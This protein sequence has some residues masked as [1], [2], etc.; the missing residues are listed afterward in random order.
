M[1]KKTIKVDGRD[2]TF[3]VQNDSDYISLTDISKLSS[4]EP[5]FDTP[6]YFLGF[7]AFFYSQQNFLKP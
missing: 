3:F 1:A 2:I 4:D 6:Q 7:P 5:R